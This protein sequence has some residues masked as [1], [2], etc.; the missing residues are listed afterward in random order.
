MHDVMDEDPTSL[1]ED[2]AAERFA[3]RRKQKRVQL[4]QTEGFPPVFREKLKDLAFPEN[5]PL[6]LR[7]IVDGNPSPKITWYRND[8]PM[9]RN[10]RTSTHHTE[11]GVS[12]LNISPAIAG[13]AGEYKCVARNRLGEVACRARV[14][15]G[16]PPDPPGWPIVEKIGH[17][18]VHIH[19]QYPAFDGNSEVLA[20][21]VEYRTRNDNNWNIYSEDLMNEKVTVRNLQPGTYYRFRAAAHNIFGWSNSSYSSDEVRTLR[22][23]DLHGH[24]LHLQ[25][26]DSLAPPVLFPHPTHIRRPSGSVPISSVGPKPVQR[27]PGSFEKVSVTM[28]DGDPN[29]LFDIR[30]EI[31][32]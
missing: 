22:P 24:D 31:A 1:I 21:K 17:D 20:Y 25:A 9:E 3:A 27:I 26:S 23:D 7:V 6:A 18:H 19:W 5:K 15:V 12:I 14:E 29:E 10:P 2:Y 30:K 16:S 28:T 4:E 8:V 32:R 11:N 13:D